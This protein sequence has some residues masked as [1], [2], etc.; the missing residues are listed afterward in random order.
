MDKF[1]A[2]TIFNAVIEEGTMSGAA[3]RLGIANS[4]VSKNLNELESWLGCK[5]IYRS[6]RSLS[7]SLEGE[8]YYEKIKH[9]VNDV[10]A[11]EQSSEI[12]DKELT[13]SIK[14]TAPVILGERL[15]KDV[16]PRFHQEYPGI[17]INMILNDDFND[18]V[19]EGV[20]IAIRST[21]L[22]DSNLIARKVG[23]QHL[24]LVTSLKYVEKCGAP[25]GPESLNRHV[26][27]ADTSVSS[28]KRWNFKNKDNGSMSVHID[29]PIEVNSANS[30][31]LLCESGMGIAQV[32]EIFV[33]KAISEGRLIELLPEHAVT[34]DISIVYHQRGVSSKVIKALI[35]FLSSNIDSELFI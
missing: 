12:D 21:V 7:L 6:T 14:M 27:I 5:L 10:V 24:K 4:V 11:L 28:A 2:M 15:C 18:I 29:G 22:P 34:L 3:R 23:T 26:C 8:S 32:P 19:S 13:G 9:I 25:I 33:N 20:D 1:K 31:V 16:L 30:V 17:K 35:D